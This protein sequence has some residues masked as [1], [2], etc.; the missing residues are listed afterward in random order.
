MAAP[1]PL[2]DAPPG[3][4]GLL[5]VRG[6][7]MPVV[8]ARAALGGVPGPPRPDQH[9]VVLEAGGRRVALA[10]DRVTEVR[11]L[12]EGARTVTGADTVRLEEGVA[13]VQPARAWL[14]RSGLPGD[15]AAPGPATP[16]TRT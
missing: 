10:V 6:E 13:V 3:V 8:D 5:D 12:A 4:R 1:S 16:R 2:P 15:G 9:L 7:V 11:E 14:A